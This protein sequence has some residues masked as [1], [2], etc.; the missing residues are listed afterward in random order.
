MKDKYWMQTIDSSVSAPYV[1]PLYPKKKSKISIS[2]QVGRDEDLLDIRLVSFQLGREMQ[3]TMTFVE[4]KNTI[5]YYQAEIDLVDEKLYYYFFVIAKDRAYSYSKT[6]LKASVPPLVECFSLKANLHEVAWVS[7]ASCYQ[8]FPDRFKNGDPDV[9]AKEGQYSFNGGIVS[10]HGFDELPL[11]FEQARCL[12]FFNGDLKGIEMSIEHFKS[13]GINT[14]YLN[15]IGC[16]RTTHRYDCIDFFHIDE[17]LG[18]DAAFESLCRTLHENGMK[19]I[20]DISIN[21]TGTDHPWYQKALSDPD[22]EEASFF[23][24]NKDGTVAFWQDVP[25]LPQLNYNSKTLRD[26]IYRDSDSVMR[27]FLKEPYLQDGWRL[28]VASEVGR[29]GEDQL[30][31]EI[32]REVR[33]SLKK[34]RED[35]Y[36]VG[37]DWVDSTPFLQGDMWDATMNYLGS[38]RPMRSWMGETDRQLS[39]GWGQTPQPCRAFDGD[40]FA[41]ALLSHLSSMPEQMLCMQMNLINSHDTPRLYEHSAI[42]DFRIYSGLVKLLYVLPGMPS[43]YYGEEIGLQGPNESVQTSRYPMQWDTK[44]WKMDFYALYKSVGKFRQTYKSLLKNGAWAILYSDRYSLVFA[45]YD[46]AKALL[47]AMSKKK[48]KHEI[49]FSNAMVCMTEIISSEALQVTLDQ[50][51]CTVV[52]EECESAL[53]V[54]NRFM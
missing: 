49:R 39:E 7:E 27:S 38:S 16:S 36:L 54:A 50:D 41:Q 46:K 11:T 37:E 33:T 14:L 6:G 40:E 23:Y 26:L 3:F 8:V 2:L 28:D 21:H 19:V 47:C 43:I 4:E 12:D 35:V 53:I 22:S 18:G 9:G 10:V 45:R 15:P 17:K 13:L 51:F 42:F 24:I 1:Q 30:C 44:R 34:E 32:W 31:E 48:G 29:K 52:L 5:C 25:T 20:V